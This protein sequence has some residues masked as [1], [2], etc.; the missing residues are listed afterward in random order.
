MPVDF[1]VGVVGIPGVAVFGTE[2]GIGDRHPH[3]VTT[4]GQERVEFKLGTVL[5]EDLFLIRQFARNSGFEL[6]QGVAGDPQPNGGPSDLHVGFKDV[7]GKGGWGTQGDIGQFH[8]QMVPFHL[9]VKLDFVLGTV[10][11]KYLFRIRQLVREFGGEFKQRVASDFDAHSSASLW[12]EIRT[13]G[14]RNPV[15]P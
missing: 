2:E 7:P 9:G 4:G 15:E 5:D 6:K 1:D 3:M 12:G 10:F 13:K 8:P 11:D 14:D